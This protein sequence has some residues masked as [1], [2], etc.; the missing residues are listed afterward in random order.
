MAFPPWLPPLAAVV[1]MQIVAAF[2]S[3]AIWVLAPVLISGESGTG[4]ELLARLIHRSGSRRDGPFVIVNCGALPETLLEAELFGHEKGAFTGAIADKFGVRR[5]TILGSLL[6]AA[7]LAVTMWA[8]S[9]FTLILGMG[10]LVGDGALPHPGDERIIEAYYAFR[11]VGWGSFTLDYQHI[12][13]PAYNA[14]RGPVDIYSA[15][16]HLEF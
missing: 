3:Q 9:S 11:P 2:Q 15:K 10:V 4:K 5:I 16:I 12:A 13:N 7:G 14:D 6:F 1:L 8:K